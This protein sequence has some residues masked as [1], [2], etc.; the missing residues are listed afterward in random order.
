MA[1]QLAS[2]RR[3]SRLSRRTRRLAVVGL[4]A[5]YP[6]LQLGYR[7]LVEPGR[8]STGIWTPV[9]I[10]LFAI[11]IVS[12]FVLY[13]YGQGRMGYPKGKLDE[14]QRAMHDRALVLSYGIVTTVVGLTLGG[15]AG[16]AMNEPVVIDMAGLVPVLIGAGLY[17]P[18][19]PFA[20]LAWIEPDL[21][22]DDEA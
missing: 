6:L 22:A 11:T 10:G 19:V 8:L 16:W 4:F 21:P 14:R 12:A 9:A 2:P 15:L 17:L 13:G 20:A 5:G 1:T 18:T 3:L 7:A